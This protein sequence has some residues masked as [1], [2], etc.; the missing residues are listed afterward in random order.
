M[1]IYVQIPAKFKHTDMFTL[2]LFY[3]IRTHTHTQAV[4]TVCVR[5]VYIWRN[6]FLIATNKFN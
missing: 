2:L 3:V 4:H 5:I 1:E 6:A